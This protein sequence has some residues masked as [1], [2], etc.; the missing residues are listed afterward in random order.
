MPKM[1][2]FRISLPL[3][4]G[5][6]VIASGPK[7]A[8]RALLPNADIS[9]S[10]TGSKWWIYEVGRDLP[11]KWPN[12]GEDADDTDGGNMVDVEY[13]GEVLVVLPEE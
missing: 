12:H 1:K 11:E 2:Q 9:L 5:E 10:R 7:E 3:K 4:R 8:L 6:K 13:A